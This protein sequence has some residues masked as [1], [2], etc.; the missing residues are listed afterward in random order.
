M[1]LIRNTWFIEAVWIVISF[2]LALVV[3]L[4]ILIYGVEFPFVK[5]N[6]MFVM[7]FITFCR[8]L[9]LWKFTPYAWFKLGKLALVFL[10]IPVIF[11]GLNQFY[12][13]RNFLDEIGIQELLTK[14]NENE[15]ISLSLYIRSEMIF[16]GTA[17]I[18]TS[19]LIPFKMI[20]NI[21]KQHNRNEV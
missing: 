4:P 17:F 8:W 7:G 21:W 11:F 16:F 9:F 10:M 14:F 12:D 19:F 13:F 1:N 2:I 6:V 5:M 15:Q 18:I 20:W 3:I